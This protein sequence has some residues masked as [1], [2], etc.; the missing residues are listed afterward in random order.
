MP[1]M[2]KGT[3]TYEIEMLGVKPMKAPPPVPTDVAAPPAN[4][5]KTANGAFY[6][7]LKK[8]TGTEKPGPKAR[9]KIEY[10]GWTTAGRLFDSSII[11]GEPAV[12]QLDRMIRGWTEGL[13]NMVVGE[14]IRLW[15]PP[16]LT[17]QN[18]PG[19]P[20]GMLVFDLELLEILPPQTTPGPAIR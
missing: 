7:Q 1:P 19:N 6:R 4:A 16:E 3:L 5:T 10:T 9:L 12:V 15:L 2:A 8:G 17:F 13:S 14:K 11:R 20:Q 18:E